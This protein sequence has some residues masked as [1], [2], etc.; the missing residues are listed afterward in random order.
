MKTVTLVMMLVKDSND[1][2][3]DDE[4][5]WLVAKRPSNMPVYLSDG[6][7]QTI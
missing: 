2:N 3:S 6:S 4:V 1:N 7:A 5:G